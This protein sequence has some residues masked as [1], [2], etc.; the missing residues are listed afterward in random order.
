MIVIGVAC[1][2]QLADVTIL[3]PKVCTKAIDGLLILLIIKTILEPYTSLT[4]QFTFR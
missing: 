4:G 1:V 2:L 3:K